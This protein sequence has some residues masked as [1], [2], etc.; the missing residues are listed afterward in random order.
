MKENLL[1]IAII[2]LFVVG[3]DLRY[4]WNHSPD[5]FVNHNL[6]RKTRT[7][8]ERHGKHFRFSG[9][10]LLW[11]GFLG[12][13]FFREKEYSFQFLTACF[14]AFM[15]FISY[16]LSDGWMFLMKKKKK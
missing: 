1:A 12:T 4:N 14:L 9:L 6:D 13:Y 8:F 3:L 10:A 16:V 2:T 11:L 15:G 5:F 7:F